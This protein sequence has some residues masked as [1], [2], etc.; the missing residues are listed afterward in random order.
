MK[1]PLFYS[2]QYLG[3]SFLFKKLK[4]LL[5]KKQSEEPLMGPSTVSNPKP[6]SGLWGMKFG[7]SV[8]PSGVSNLK[9]P[10]GLRGIKFGASRGT[11]RGQ[12]RMKPLSGLRGIKSGASRGAFGLSRMSALCSML[13]A[14]QCKMLLAC[15]R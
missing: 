10:S 1:Y 8:G 6:L 2:T 5:V 15:M 12:I 4:N 3:K 7:A 11:F 9:P 13:H 14:M